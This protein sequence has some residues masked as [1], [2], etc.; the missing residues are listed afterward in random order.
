[1]TSEERRVVGLRERKKA[2]TMASIQMNALRLFRELGYNGTTVEQIAEAAEISPSTFFRY[3][4]TKEDVVLS[5]NYD[6]LII[7]AFEEQPADLTPL[8]A[9]RSAIRMVMSDISQEEL[10][11]MRERSHLIM[12]IP[13]LRG[14]MLNGFIGTLQMFAEIV[15]KRV[16]RSPDDLGVRTLAGAI[17]GVNI[18]I[19]LYYVDDPNADIISLLDEALGKLEAGLSL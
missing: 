9:V 12:T 15:G 14:A 19:M 1:M 8:Q 4:P 13:E 5:D 16:G 6:P 18:S 10:S 17:I 3:F 11:A 2:K 7:A